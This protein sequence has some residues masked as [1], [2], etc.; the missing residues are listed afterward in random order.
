MVLTKRVKVFIVEQYFRSYG[1]GLSSGQNLLHVGKGCNGFGNSH[2]RSNMVMLQVT[3]ILRSIQ[4]EFTAQNRC[5]PLVTVIRN[6]NQ[7]SPVDTVYREKFS[8]EHP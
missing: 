3:K 2:L 7:G 8:G 4:V 1:V 5:D 6:A